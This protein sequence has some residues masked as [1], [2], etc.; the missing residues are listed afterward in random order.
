MRRASSQTCDVG[1]P[2]LKSDVPGFRGC[3]LAR[4][5]PISQARSRGALYKPAAFE[6]S[7]KLKANLTGAL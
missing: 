3:A 5:N 1:C 4:W 2:L 6:S 7:D